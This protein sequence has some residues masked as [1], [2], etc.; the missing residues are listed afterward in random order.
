MVFDAARPRPPKKAIPMAGLIRVLHIEEDHADTRLFQEYLDE[1]PGDYQTE[2][3]RRLSEGVDLLSRESF[4]VVLMD[5]GLPDAQGIDAFRRVRSV[6]PGI[7]II[8]LSRLRD[9]KLARR[10]VHE[11]AQDY[12]IKGEVEGQLLVRAMRYAMERKRLTR[13]LAEYADELRA[14][15]AQLEADFN[16]ARD[17]QQV[18]LPNRY[19]VFP[20]WAPPSQSA[21]K[22]YHRYIPAAA[23]GGDF[24]DGAD[25][26]RKQGVFGAINRAHTALTDRPGNAIAIL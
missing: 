19:P 4:D 13:Q 6:V 1:S 2:V 16:M 20:K 12:L 15:N 17:I 9:K 23:V 26:P 18:F 14:K 24:F 10:A 7:P 25:A 22:F 11:G 8:V 3:G 21:L 5:L